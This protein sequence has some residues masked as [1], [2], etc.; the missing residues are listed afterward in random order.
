MVFTAYAY[1]ISPGRDDMLYFART[2][3]ECRL[4]AL[5]HRAE[6]RENDDEYRDHLGAMALYEC[7]MKVPDPETLIRVMNVADDPNALFKACVVERHLIAVVA[8]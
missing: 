4:E 1:Q 3:A 8:E 2:F 6:I 5:Q 7:V